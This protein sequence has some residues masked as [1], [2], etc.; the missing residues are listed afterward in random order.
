MYVGIEISSG[1]RFITEEGKRIAMSSS[2]GDQSPFIMLL[3]FCSCLMDEA[4]PAK[5]F[6][7]CPYTVL[8]K[9]CAG[10]EGDKVDVQKFFGYIGL[11]TLIG[12]WWLVWPLTAAGIEPKFTIPHSASLE[13]VLLLN[14]LMGSVLSDYFWSLS[15]V[16]TTPLVATLGMSLTIPLAM[17]ADMVIHGR[18][19]STVYISGC[20]QVFA[21]FVIANLSDKFSCEYDFKGSVLFHV[22]KSAL[23]SFS[24]LS[25]RAT[26]YCVAMSI[27]PDPDLTYIVVVVGVTTLLCLV[28]EINILKISRDIYIERVCVFIDDDNTDFIRPRNKE[29]MRIP[30]LTIVGSSDGNLHGGAVRCFDNEEP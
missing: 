4:V 24:C 17:I 19:Y 7:F 14:G 16:W 11:F 6:Q 30:S 9:R 3:F 26:L 1:L 21:G 2:F 25:C 27:V 20:I 15:V 10:S 13:E 28:M 29:P 5:D 22:S 8:L 23:D 18:H 12:L